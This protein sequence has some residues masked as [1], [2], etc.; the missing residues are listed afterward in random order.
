MAKTHD[1][2]SLIVKESLKKFFGEKDL[3]SRLQKFDEIIG[4]IVQKAE[5]EGV[6]PEIALQNATK[7]MTLKIRQK[8]RQ[9]Y[10]NQEAYTRVR[11]QVDQFGDKDLWRGIQS[12]IAIEGGYKYKAETA[13]LYGRREALQ[14]ISI[15]LL[16]RNLDNVQLKKFSSGEYDLEIKKILAGEYD[17]AALG[18]MD[19]DLIIIAENARKMQD[20]LHQVKNQAGLDVGYTKNRIG[21]QFHSGPGMIE[22]GERQWKALAREKFDL[23]KMGLNTEKEVVDRLD[24]IWDKRTSNTGH[25][26]IQGVSDDID[27]IT[28]QS[29]TKNMGSNR[30]VHFLDAESAHIYDQEING[31]KNLMTSLMTEIE[32]DSGKV[33][34]VELLGPN[35][36]AT[37]TKVMSEVEMPDYRRSSLDSQFNNTVYGTKGKGKGFFPGTVDTVKKIS[38]MVMLGPKTLMSTMTD[39]AYG[40]MVLSADTGKNMLQA[41]ADNISSILKTFPDQKQAALQGSVFLQDAIDSTFNTNFHENGLVTNWFDKTHDFYMKAT[42]LP[43]QSRMFKT[44]NANAFNHIMFNNRGTAFDALDSGTRNLFDRY[45]IGTEEWSILSKHEGSNL[46][47]GREIIDVLKILDTDL[48]EFSG[49]VTQKRFKRNELATNYNAMLVE[50]AEA[51]SPT[52]TSQTMHWVEQSDPHTPLG[53]AARLAGQFKSFAFSMPKTLMRIKGADPINMKSGTRLASAVL[54]ATTLRYGV[55]YLR[56]IYD[57]KEPPDATDP[58]VW[59]KAAASSGVGGIYADMLSVDYSTNIWRDPVKDM[60]GPGARVLTDAVKGTIEAGKYVYQTFEGDEHEADKNMAKVLKRLEKNTALPFIQN[61]LNK[62]I[63][64]HIHLLMNT[65]AKR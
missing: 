56:A 16:S 5:Q 9:N 13:S 35:F 21:K 44:A 31:S 28:I 49:T 48:N 64:D 34:A 55:E 18:K 22:Y 38:N 12:L 23:K 17:E 62:E 39:M 63:Y 52:P 51:G 7:D 54:A 24:S 45:G 25:K 58:M 15:G 26:F 60:A 46:P 47:D 41:A 36:S 33:A 43:M 4:D 19:K 3:D 2:C 6:S 65:G 29:S 1:E 20:H 8:A 42:G 32:R 30:S 27:E 40:P 59:T 37:W 57:G 50:F 61:K 53:M 11:K 10:L 14:N